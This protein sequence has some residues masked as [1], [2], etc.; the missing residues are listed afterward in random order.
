MGAFGD[1]LTPRSLGG[2]SSRNARVQIGGVQ[3]A[4]L[5]AVERG[6][7]EILL[8]VRGCQRKGKIGISAAHRATPRPPFD[9][10]SNTCFIS[11]KNGERPDRP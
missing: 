2:R 6:G 8:V 11:L 3:P 7:G 10:V 4:V 5:A 9:A 1:Q